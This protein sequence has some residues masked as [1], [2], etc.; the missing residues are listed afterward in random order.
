MKISSPNIKRFE[1]HAYVLDFIQNC[2]SAVVKN[3]EGPIAYVLGLKFFTLLEVLIK[4]NVPVRLL[5]QIY[6]GIDKSKR[7]IVLSVLGK[8]EPSVLTKQAKERLPYACRKIIFIRIE[9]FNNLLNRENFPLHKIDKN[10]RRPIDLK[11]NNDLFD[12]VVSRAVEEL[13]GSIPKRKWI[14]AG[15]EG[16]SWIPRVIGKKAKYWTARGGIP[17]GSCLG[18]EKL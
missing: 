16:R 3:R 17:V 4:E 18:S 11:V 8:I 5:E 14:I 6:I 10:A 1:D 7:D 2:K 12:K 15:E 9:E 13:N